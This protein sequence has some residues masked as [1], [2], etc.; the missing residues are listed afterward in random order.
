MSVVRIEGDFSAGA[1]VRA[2]LFGPNGTRP[3]ARMRITDTRAKRLPTGR[4]EKLWSL[5]LAGTATVYEARIGG[6]IEGVEYGN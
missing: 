1:F 5:E 3:R 2:A 4:A 6:S